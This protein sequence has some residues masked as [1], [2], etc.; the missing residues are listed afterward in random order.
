MVH[1]QEEL[2]NKIYKMVE[3]WEDRNRGQEIG[4]KWGLGIELKYLKKNLDEIKYLLSKDNI[5]SVNF[6]NDTEFLKLLEHNMMI[7][8]RIRAYTTMYSHILDENAVHRLL[9]ISDFI[10]FK[11][12][13]RTNPSEKVIDDFE[14]TRKII[15][16]HDIKF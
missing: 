5:K 7:S 3:L 13:L 8:E 12:D 1:N 11:N 15:E 6:F 10:K 14:K 4:A 9:R 2:V 16:E